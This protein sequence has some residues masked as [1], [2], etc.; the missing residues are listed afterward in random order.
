[1]VYPVGYVYNTL[2]NLRKEILSYGVNTHI[3]NKS[4]REIRSPADEF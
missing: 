2:Q 3:M 1:M 4:R